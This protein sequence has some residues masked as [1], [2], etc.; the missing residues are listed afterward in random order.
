MIYVFIH[1]HTGDV[2]PFAAGRVGLQLLLV[3]VVVRKVKW[4]AWSADGLA[5]LLCC[6][7]C[8]LA[9]RLVGW[10][11]P[12]HCI[13]ATLRADGRWSPPTT[14]DDTSNYVANKET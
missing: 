8:S 12:L 9:G 11:L 2:S 5:R 13:S 6:C 14:I 10:L 4:P 3:V 7:C 1:T